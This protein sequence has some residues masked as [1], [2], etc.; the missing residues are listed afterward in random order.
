[1]LRFLRPRMPDDDARRIDAALRERED[2]SIGSHPAV[3][4]WKATREALLHSA[5]A[6]L[7]GSP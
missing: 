1:M 6:T 4:P 5:D 7:P 3:E 2:E